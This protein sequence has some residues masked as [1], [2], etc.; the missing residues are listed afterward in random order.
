MNTTRILRY[1][2]LSAISL[3]SLLLGSG[4]LPA[5]AQV[6]TTN[7]ASASAPTASAAKPALASP[8]LVN[9]WLRQQSPAFKSWDIGGQFR[10]RYE[11]KDNAGSFP[12]RD[13]IAQDQDNSND[14]LMER[15]R[16]HLGYTPVSWFTA[17]VEGCNSL[18][19]W[20]KRVPSLDLNTANLR[21]AF[22]AFGDAK[23]FPLLAKV[24]RQELLYGEERF[25]G[26]ANWNNIGRTFDA[27]K[28]RY[29]SSNFWLDAFAG[30]MVVPYDG[31][32]NVANDYDWL[33]GLYGSLPKLVPWQETEFYFLSRN[34]GKNAP[35]AIAPGLPGTPTTARDIYTYG[36]RWA[37]T[38]GKLGGWDYSLEAAGQFG[39]INQANVR[40][41]QESYAVFASSGYT[42]KK[43]WGSPRFGLGYEF[44]SGDSNPNDGK[45]QTFENLFGTNHRFYGAMDLFCERNMH[46]PRLCAS[47]KPVKNLT[48]SSEYL[49]FWLAD[50][51]D[52]LYP[53]SGSGRNANGYGRHPGFDSF[54]GSE[55]DVV[56]TYSFKGLADLQLGYGHFFVSDYIK[57]SVGSVAKNGGAVDANW[58]YVQARFNF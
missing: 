58:F 44:G 5:V 54:V 24:G 36:T 17:Y 16:Y 45:N 14:Y 21:Q 13:F 4:A 2:H 31:H 20:D 57:Q 22:V 6:P 35:N 42:W 27:A 39:S 32:F 37:S 43:A 3:G 49:L 7:A 56:A 23:Q 29:E 51:H 25:V 19:Q 18:E 50:T 30:R 28:L 52:Y 33:L 1:E 38:P 55:I 12:N 47:L 41:D 8:G 11:L 34:V 46:I 48:I 53:E 40:R 26:N 9:D 15:L 10:L